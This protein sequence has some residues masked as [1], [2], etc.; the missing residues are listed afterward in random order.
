[1]CPVRGMGKVVA[2]DETSATEPS[3]YN[4]RVLLEGEQVA[5]R[6]GLDYT[7]VRFGG[8][9]G[10]GRMRLLVARRAL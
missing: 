9:Y 5:Q 6:S 2:R 4:G 1:M 3:R 7:N 10:P 8:I